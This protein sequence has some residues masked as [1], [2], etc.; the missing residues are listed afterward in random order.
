MVQ[1]RISRSANE[2]ELVEE[3]HQLDQR[4]ILELGCGRAELTRRIAGTGRGRKIT[5]LEVD[6]VQHRLNLTLADLPNV[7]FGLGGAQ[8]IPAPD[9]GFDVAFLFKSLHH[10]PVEHMDAALRELARVLKPDGRLH[11][12]EP[13]FLGSFNEVLRLFHDEQLVR[14]E[15]YAAIERAVAAGLFRRER[16]VF[17]LAPLHFDDFADF[18]ARIL[19]VSHTEHRLSAQLAGEVRARFQAHVGADGANFMQPCRIDLLRR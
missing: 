4:A 8:D 17:Y 15:A 16:Q 14:E 3:L 11:I 13:L 9:A 7:R 19:N 18:E 10:V 12:S 2:W 6:E 1:R 5:A